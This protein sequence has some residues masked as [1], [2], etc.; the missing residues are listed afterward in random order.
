MPSPIRL[1]SLPD[2]VL[3]AIA[4]FMPPSGLIVM[5]QSSRAIA[6]VLQDQ[7]SLRLDEMFVLAA[8]NNIYL[9]P[10][11]LR[12]PIQPPLCVMAALF[13]EECVGDDGGVYCHFIEASKGYDGSP[14]R[15]ELFTQDNVSYVLYGRRSAVIDD[16]S[17]RDR[18]A[19]WLQRRCAQLLPPRPLTV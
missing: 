1:W 3:R 11:I 5:V 6:A 13:G 12:L 7:L 19:S 9:H 17:I 14:R 8:P 15:L 10:Y 16:V 18:F 4:T 2:D